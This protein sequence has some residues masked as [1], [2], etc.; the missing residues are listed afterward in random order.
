[1]EMWK[2][3]KRIVLE[4]AAETLDDQAEKE[5]VV[6]V[7]GKLV[8]QVIGGMKNG[9]LMEASDQ[10]KRAIPPNRE[11]A[12]TLVSGERIKLLPRRF[13]RR[14]SRSLTNLSP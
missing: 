9:F 8:S 12:I 7:W 3:F 13:H 6:R 14:L 5:V 10:W 1:M 11:R 2:E 4:A